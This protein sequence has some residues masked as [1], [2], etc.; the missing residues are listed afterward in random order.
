MNAV[1]VLLGS[2]TASSPVGSWSGCRCCSAG[3]WA[4]KG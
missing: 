3:P 2:K 4:E 1:K